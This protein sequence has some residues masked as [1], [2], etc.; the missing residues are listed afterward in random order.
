MHVCPYPHAC[1]TNRLTDACCYWNGSLTEVC[2]DHVVCSLDMSG[3]GRRCKK[4]LHLDLNNDTS[5]AKTNTR[6]ASYAARSAHDRERIEWSL[7]QRCDNL[8]LAS[9]ENVGD[10]SWSHISLVVLHRSCSQLAKL[11][12]ASVVPCDGW[13]GRFTTIASLHSDLVLIANRV[14][15]DLAP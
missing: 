6:T 13:G 3:G 2:S 8:S 4:S 12:G 7:K 15:K 1:W 14:C 5:T 10:V 11:S 9:D